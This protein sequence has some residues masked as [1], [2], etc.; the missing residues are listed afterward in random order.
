MAMMQ[1]QEKQKMFELAPGESWTPLLEEINDLMTE[2]KLAR[3]ENDHV[4]VSEIS[5]RIVSDT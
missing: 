2:E 3:H 1:K 5:L 4:K